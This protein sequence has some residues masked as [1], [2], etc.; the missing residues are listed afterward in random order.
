[1][2]CTIYHGFLPKVCLFIVIIYIQF[3]DI[4]YYTAGVFKLQTSERAVSV[5]TLL[6]KTLE[7]NFKASICT[8]IAKIFQVSM[9]WPK[10]ND[11]DTSMMSVLS[12]IARPSSFWTLELT[13]TILYSPCSSIPV[14]SQESTD[15]HI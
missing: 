13:P 2:F 12:P 14:I 1:M 10:Q 7:T 11:I 4:V 15:H 3:I 9:A 8:Y 5:H 6:V